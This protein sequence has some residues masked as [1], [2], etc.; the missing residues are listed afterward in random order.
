MELLPA[1][2]LRRGLVVRLRQG[3]AA[4]AT[5]YGDDPLAVAAAFAAAGARRIHAV[6]L[7]AAFGEPPQRDLVSRLAALL[8]GAAAAP[9]AGAE[10][11]QRDVG[12][13][14]KRFLGT[15][16]ALAGL[17]GKPVAE[18][19]GILGA[20]GWELAAIDHSAPAGG[21]SRHYYVFKRMGEGPP[22]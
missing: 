21:P 3:D 14:I 10:R 16:E 8:A 4:S 17:H 18:V 7:D 12:G 19:L 22:R 9:A 6:D 20:E 15:E 13:V 1:I 11:R 2:D 5:V